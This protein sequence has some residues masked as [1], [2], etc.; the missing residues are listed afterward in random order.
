MSAIATIFISWDV[1]FEYIAIIV[2]II[3][4]IVNLLLTRYKFYVGGRT[5]SIALVADAYHSKTDIWSSLA[6]LAGL[7]GAW[8]GFPVLDS[9]AGIV[10]SLVIMIG[11]VRIILEAKKL[12]GSD[13]EPDLEKF[14]SYIER[15]ARSL[16]DMGVLYGLWLLKLHPMTRQELNRRLRE[17]FLGKRFPIPLEE[18]DYEEIF[19][20]L[21][22]DNLIIKKSGKIHLTH[23]GEKRIDA[24]LKSSAKMVPWFERGTVIP[25]WVAWFAEGL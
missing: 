11:G 13:D 20:R 8:L 3:T 14:S 22:D 10:V 23:D 12:L 4:I 18:S 15:H 2:I 25:R 7:F 21:I 17:G 24:L 5:R 9:V 16:L 6:A 19:G 1:R